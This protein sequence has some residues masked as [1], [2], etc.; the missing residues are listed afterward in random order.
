MP[1]LCSITDLGISN[2]WSF[3]DPRLGAN[4]PAEML[5]DYV[6]VYQEVSTG[7]GD[8]VLTIGDTMWLSRTMV[9]RMIGHTRSYGAVGNSAGPFSLTPC[10]RS[11]VRLC[12][13]DNHTRSAVSCHPFV[14]VP[15]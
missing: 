7:I 6:R 5:I 11:C 14:P 4:L 12:S 13:H 1:L 3:V 8:Q 2:S 10:S 15:T 9:T